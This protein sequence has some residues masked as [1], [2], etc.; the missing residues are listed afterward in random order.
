MFQ[1][2]HEKVQ[3]L[4]ILQYLRY[5]QLNY[6]VAKIWNYF[7]HC[8]SIETLSGRCWY[9]SSFSS[10]EFLSYIIKQRIGNIYFDVTF[11]C[12]SIFHGLTFDYTLWETSGRR[13]LR[14][15]PPCSGHYHDHGS[16][17]SVTPKQLSF[18]VKTVMVCNRILGTKHVTISKTFRFPDGPLFLL[19][20]YAVNRSGMARPTPERTFK[21]K[22]LAAKI[23]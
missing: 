12:N 16:D 7:Q 15:I 20:P 18:A 14:P 17:P 19:P 3:N 10:F 8:A 9:L 21:W 11:P 2:T 4:P 1:K 23:C 13:P 6:T 22:K 5:I